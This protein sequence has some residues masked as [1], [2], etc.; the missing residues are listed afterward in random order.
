MALDIYA[1]SDQNLAP[2]DA[3]CPGPSAQDIIAR[4]EGEIPAPL[5]AQRYEFL[6]DEDISWDRYTSQ[7]FYDLEVE[8]MWSKTWQ[9]A[10]REEHIPN[11]GDY[12]VYDIADYS[13][14][15][16]RGDDDKIRAFVNSCPH[17]GMQFCEAGESGSGKQFLR[18]PFH[19]MSWHLDGSL[20]E[21]PCRWDFP[22]I[23]DDEFKLIE[24]PSDTWG[25]F[26][27]INL[28]RD[29]KLLDDYLEVLPEHFANW[30]LDQRY[31][32]MHTEKVLPGNWKMCMEGF[33]EAYHVLAT[34]PEGLRSS[35]W[36]NT[37]Y[38]LFSPNVTR[39]LQNL[40]S[41]NPHFEKKFTEAELFEFMGY[42]AED[43]PTGK[44]ARQQHADNLRT[45]LGGEMDVDLSKLSNS[46]MLD[47]IEYHL[48]P[49]ACFF[50]GIVIPLIYRFRPLGVDKCI[51]DI[52]L[53][54]PVPENGP[55]PAPADKEAL[56]IDEPY[57]SL[58]S[59]KT[60]RLS[61]VL[62][63]D[64]DNFKRQWAGVKASLKGTQTLGNYQEARIRHFHH[65]LDQYLSS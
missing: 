30:P 58:D 55:R 28:D 18:C 19:G 46:E 43:L 32:I 41:G 37:Q 52:M 13:V 31:V 63:Q 56:A 35:G 25:G 17:R 48:F 39:F 64:T 14:I 60:N 24:V 53:L 49:N 21:I 5:L 36:A 2:G 10:C 1:H 65:T 27:F 9:W 29:A 59:F 44:S 20:R 50:P 8:K 23:Q 3:R 16:I 47:S 33:L 4:D 15:V 40:S 22:H 42:S 12:Y 7:A 61:A 11:P 57:V 34:H 26:V 45:N 62:D 6:G 54:R 38:D 51:H